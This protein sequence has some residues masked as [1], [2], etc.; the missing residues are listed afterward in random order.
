MKLLVYNKTISHI[1]NLLKTINIIIEQSS[2]YN[3]SLK[4]E[5]LN[6][7]KKYKKK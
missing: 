4:F 1:V 5:S 3:D 6:Y 2:S 7:L